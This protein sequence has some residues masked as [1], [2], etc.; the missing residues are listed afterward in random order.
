MAELILGLLLL[1]IA[2]WI[3][4][5][6]TWLFKRRVSQ[7]DPKFPAFREWIGN[8]FQAVWGL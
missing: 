3:A 4:L 5:Y 7:G 2:G 1:L 6:S 8:L